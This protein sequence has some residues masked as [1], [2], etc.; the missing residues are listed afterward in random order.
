MIKKLHIVLSGV[1]NR[2]LPKKPETSNWL[3][4]VELINRSKGFQLV[5]V[6][7]ISKESMK[8]IVDRGYL[9]VEQTYRDFDRMLSKVT[10]DAILIS[11]PAQ[12]HAATI[13]KA[14]DFNLHVLVEKP[15]VND[16]TEGRKLVDLIQKKNKTVAVIQNWRCKD[17][18]RLLY[19]T[20][21]N[22]MLGKIGH[23]FFRYV[24]NRENPDYPSYIFDEEYPLLY[25]MGIHHLDLFR[26]ILDDEYESV[27]G[28][29]F[30]P[31]WSLYKSDTGL[32]LFLKTKKGVSIV[33]AG[34]ISSNS[35]GIL[36]ESLIVEG[37]K[38]SLV[39]ESQWLE[40]PL[41]F[42]PYGN[43]KKKRINLAQKI[44]DTSIQE[45][46]NKSDNYI[47]KNFCRSIINLEEPNCS[48]EDGL[49]SVAIVEACR[50][51]CE[52]GKVIYIDQI[53]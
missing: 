13:K 37:E 1:G 9:T 2:A 8:R 53:V 11:N 21:Q 41:W 24:R 49:R 12:Y 25:A 51:A 52:T 18:G 43:G 50:L 36:Q 16:L 28:S 5:A 15:F 30:K 44:T 34:T 47:L 31:P 7:D 29:S 4:W 38:G 46:Y 35:K 45:Q 14:L 48:A 19:E 10:C 23:I 6:H 26:Y 3:G 33:Y 20:I 40:P 32:H 27:R 17:V 42:Y 22:G 39:N